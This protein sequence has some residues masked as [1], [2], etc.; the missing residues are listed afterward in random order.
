MEEN[1]KITEFYDYLRYSIS[2]AQCNLPVVVIEDIR[3]HLSKYIDEMNKEELESINKTL[4]V[5]EDYYMKNCNVVSELQNS[6]E[7]NPY[8]E[9]IKSVFKEE[10]ANL[11]IKL[12]RLDFIRNFVISITDIIDAKVDSLNDAKKHV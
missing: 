10:L 9:E 7:K 6:I 3:S 11:S 5:Y 8:N 1:V 12:E 2:M 4:E